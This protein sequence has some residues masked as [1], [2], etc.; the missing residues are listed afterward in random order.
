MCMNVVAAFSPNRNIKL[1][2]QV[3]RIERERERERE[4]EKERERE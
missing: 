4:R 1:S 3:L 2:K